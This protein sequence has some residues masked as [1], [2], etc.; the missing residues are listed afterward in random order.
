MARLNYAQET[1]PMHP[2]TPNEDSDVVTVA[3][4]N[5]GDPAIQRQ[6]PWMAI[7]MAMH[8]LLLLIAAFIVAQSQA[9][10]PIERLVTS[11]ENLE[12]PTPPQEEEPPELINP[13]DEVLV[14]EIVIK[15]VE[16]EV[17]T[18]V[19]TPSDLPE[20]L[21][22]SETDSPSPHTGPNS[23]FG[24]GGG[25]GGGN[26]P[27]GGP[28]GGNIS[29]PERPS[30][31][32]P[33]RVDAALQWLADHQ[34][35]AGHWSATNFLNDSIRIK[36]ATPAA[37]TRT[38]DF[39]DHMAKMRGSGDSDTGHEAFNTGLTGLALLAFVTEGIT[40]KGA[41][42]GHAR[43]SRTVHR[44]TM[45]VMA[46]QDAEGCF[47]ARDDEEF[48]YSHAICT[49][50]LAEL[51]DL[52]L[53]P[54]IRGRAQRGV[55]FIIRCQN[56]GQGWR[57][58]VQPKENDTSVT[59]WMVLALKSAKGAGLAFD[60]DASYAGAEAWFTKATGRDDSG[61]QKTGYDRPAGG[62]SR[63]SIAAQYDMNPSM[64]AC[65]VMSRLFM[66]T[67]STGD[68][69]VRQQ[70]QNMIAAP[71]AWT[72]GGDESNGPWKIDM[73]YWYYA[74]LALFQLGDSYWKPWER[75]L[76]QPVLLKHQ[77]GYHPKDVAAYGKQVAN[78]VV[79]FKDG[80]ENPEAGRWI[81]D[82]HGSWD[83]L[84]PWGSAGGRVYSTAINALTLQVYY[85]YNKIDQAVK[86]TK[87]KAGE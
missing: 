80:T 27:G 37:V 20:M 42:E 34:N 40:H 73:Y 56:P 75:E 30:G 23:P 59:A 21:N 1:A 72:I 83:P 12:L 64:D 61:Y 8:G 33:E 22:P 31:T 57:Y 26:G 78:S 36:R 60:Q 79:T 69:L 70:A 18:D 46:S 48:V 17:E 2:G 65:A 5:E 54:V 51:Y 71:A 66:G 77:R 62:N 82:E 29:R 76:I 55:D 6:L 9:P 53:S 63:F 13:V 43:F 86:K 39:R 74:S 28:P 85:R 49:M 24:F 15:P 58:G 3:A 25:G 52:T 7:A 45:A 50:A 38:I 81:L 87:V 47:G 41:N 14:D 4:E 68:A 16:V 11:L 67:A 44:A 32:H 84:D 35:P 10:K 19:V